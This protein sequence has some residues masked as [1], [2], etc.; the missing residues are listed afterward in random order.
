MRSNNSDSKPFST[1]AG[2]TESDTH[3]SGQRKT[4]HSPFLTGRTE[5]EQTTTAPNGYPQRTLFRSP[6][7]SRASLPQTSEEFYSWK[8]QPTQSQEHSLSANTPT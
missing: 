6:T 1:V 3:S 4:G 7:T 5:D 2:G 8:D